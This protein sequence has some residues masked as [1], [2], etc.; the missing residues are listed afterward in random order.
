MKNGLELVRID[1]P[2]L[3]SVVPVDAASLDDV[4]SRVEDSGRAAEGCGG[5]GLQPS[6]PKESANRI[7]PRAS[8]CFMILRIG[9]RLGRLGRDLLPR[10]GRFSLPVSVGFVE[11]S[12]DFLRKNGSNNSARVSGGFEAFVLGLSE[13]D[14]D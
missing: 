12:E 7:K 9:Q 14:C 10:W 11:A 1:K 4:V 5:D 8:R 6:I 2:I 3:R 13:V